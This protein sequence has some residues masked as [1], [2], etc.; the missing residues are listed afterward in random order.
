M[1]CC[2]RN[3]SKLGCRA[4]PF[5]YWPF[6]LVATNDVNKRRL[7]AAF[8]CRCGC[9]VS[10]RQ[11][12][13]WPFCEPINASNVH[14]LA[15]NETT[16]Q[17]CRPVNSFIFMR[18]STQTLHIWFTSLRVAAQAEF[19]CFVFVLIRDGEKQAEGIFVGINILSSLRSCL[20]RSQGG[21]SRIN[22]EFNKLSSSSE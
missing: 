10:S 9:I 20:T 5:R 14:F 6:N 21:R 18:V 3:Y 4:F 19:S 7:K 15:G 2:Q 22:F 16:N 11:S 12:V 17:A 13:N 8:S 1:T